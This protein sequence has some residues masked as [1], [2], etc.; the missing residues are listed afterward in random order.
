MAY[1]PRMDDLPLFVSF[2]RTGAHWI[3]CVMELY[4]D[5]PRLREGRTTFL[6]KARTDWMWFHDHDFDLDLRHADVLFLYRDPVPTIF[7]NLAYDKARE[8]GGFWKRLLRRESASADEAEV[9]KYCD[10]YRRHL[11]KWLVSEERA[12]TQVRHERFRADALAEFRAV[13]G[14]FS[15]ALDEERARKAFATVTP[16]ALVERTGDAPEMGS[17]MLGDNYRE[18]RAAFAER[19]GETVK[20]RV[21]TPE[22]ET[23]F[24]EPGSPAKR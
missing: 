9:E 7:S 12:R 5:R 4:F 21:I 15:E 1:D 6:D 18:N 14:H 17:H 16:E 2:P 19:W 8:G 20:D 3:N 23:Y 24:G 22:L 11:T 13:C 10:L